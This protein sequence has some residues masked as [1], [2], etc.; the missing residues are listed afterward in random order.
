M[1][2]LH[3]CICICIRRTNNITHTAE[4]QKQRQ[5]SSSVREKSFRVSVSWKAVRRRCSWD[6]ELTHLYAKGIAI[7]KQQECECDL[8]FSKMNNLLNGNF[9]FN[10][11]RNNGGSHIVWSCYCSDVLSCVHM[12]GIRVCDCPSIHMV[13]LL[14]GNRVIYFTRDHREYEIRQRWWMIS[15]TLAQLFQFLWWHEVNYPRNLQ[16]IW[17]FRFYRI[18][19][20]IHIYVYGRSERHAAVLKSMPYIYVHCN[21]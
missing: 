7:S 2:P 6:W 19:I 11:K 20:W 5:W 17:S 12:Y 16:T 8:S 18:W 14:N 10:W 1:E 13:W 9:K 15:P 4:H 21:R 3:L